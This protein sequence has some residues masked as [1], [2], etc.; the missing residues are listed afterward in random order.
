[1]EVKRNLSYGATTTY[2]LMECLGILKHQTVN[3]EVAG[4]SP[5]APVA[6]NAYGK[7]LYVAQTHEYAAPECEGSASLI[8][9]IGPSSIPDFRSVIE[10]APRRNCRGGAVRGGMSLRHA[11]S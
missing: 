7:Y 5:A 1:M 6:Q 4:S 9:E 3:Q 10:L 8:R 2:K 11:L